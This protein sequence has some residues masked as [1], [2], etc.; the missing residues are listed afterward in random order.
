MNTLEDYIEYYG[1]LFG[2][3]RFNESSPSLEFC[4]NCEGY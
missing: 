2:P 1:K 3:I 4:I